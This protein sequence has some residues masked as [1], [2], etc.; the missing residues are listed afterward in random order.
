MGARVLAIL[1]T[2]GLVS[3]LVLGTMVGVFGVAAVAT[4]GALSTDLPDPSSLTSL[5][6]SQPTT[7]YDRSGKTLLATFRQEERRVVSFDDIPKLVLDATTSAEDRTFWTNEGYD[8]AAI[9]QAISENIGGQSDRGASTITQQ[10]VR[11]RLLPKEYTAPGADRYLRKA[12]ELIQSARLTE[13]FPGEAG[14]QEIIT[15]YLNEIFY[16]HD[17]YGIAAAASVYFGVADLAKLTPAQAALLAGL[18]KSPTTLDPYRYATADKDGKLVVPRD[19]PPVVRRDYILRSLSTSRWTHLTPARL[20]AALAEPVV[21]AGDRPTRYLAPHFTWQVRR[22]LEQILG[23]ADAVDRGGYRVITTLD[24]RGQTLAEKWLEAGTIAPNLSRKN[25]KRLLDRDKIPQGDRDWVAA[26]RGKDIHNGA[27]V[28]L[29]YTSGDVLAYVGSGGYYR[30]SMANAEFSPKFD[31]AGDG[32]RQPGSAFKPI[33][34]ATAFDDK[35]LSPGSLLLDITTEFNRRAN[36]AP[37]D[38]DQLDRG[39]VLVRKALQFSLNVPAIRALQRVGNE[40]VADTA[41]KLG[42]R[43]P[44][45]RDAFLQAGLAGAIGTVEVRPI[46]LTSAY[47]TI[48][49]GGQRVPPRMILEIIGPD[50]K[51][52]WQP[53]DPKPVKAISPAAAFLVSD[54]LAGNSD[55]RENPIWAAKLEMRNTRDGR[56]RPLAAKTGTANDA[57]DLG[58]YGF[59]APPADDSHP[60]LAVGLWMGNSDHSS[61]RTAKPMTS[62]EAAAPLWHAF[63]RD[64]TRNW[65]VTDFTPPEGVVQRTIDAW[66]GGR[67]GPWT[68]DTTREW[69][70]TGT[71]PGGR[72]EIDQSG[73]LYTRACGRWMVDPLQAELGP[74]AWDGDV[75]D[76]MSRARRGV[77]IAG[78]L[79]SRTAYFFGENSWGGK[80]LGPCEKPKP[81]DKPSDHD[82]KDKPPKDEPPKDKPPKDKPPDPPPNDGGGGGGGGGGDEPPAP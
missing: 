10:L 70:I 21:L 46:D 57:R 51:V 20:N 5:T 26:L 14:K 80:I 62:I 67:P 63:V 38:A 76:W 50:G 55:P 43:F 61:P 71:Q 11:A 18:P 74:S 56:R 41:D 68:R 34:Y 1:L 42:I 15:A 22:Q 17:A 65:P 64:Y 72:H 48:A 12:K 27:L 30:D 29:D 3:I 32:A 77:A 79:G 16:G 54:I 35:V 66:S 49:N 25:A 47:G 19:A 58:T 53:P 8:A 78:P 23:G 82:G 13:T 4:V 28:A 69:F 75:A 73:L 52:V 81:K 40:A 59:L 2:V 44:G 7:V 6:F 24:W 31:A 60:G 39:P 37:R 36:W 9:L 45:G 33:L